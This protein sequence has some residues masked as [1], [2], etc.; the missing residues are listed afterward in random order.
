MDSLQKQML[1][2]IV[3]EKDGI[4]FWFWCSSCQGLE[5]IAADVLKSMQLLTDCEVDLVFVE[6]AIDSSTQ[7]GRH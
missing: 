3:C 7:G 6:D 4:S 1:D 2:D 5:G